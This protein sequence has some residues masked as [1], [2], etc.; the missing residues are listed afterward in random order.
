MDEALRYAKEG[1]PRQIKRAVF[2]SG[3]PPLTPDTHNIVLADEC[4]DVI[5][6]PTVHVFG[7]SDPYAVGALALFDVCVQDSATLFD[8]GNG[9]IIPR[10]GRTLKELGGAVRSMAKACF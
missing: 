10:D 5:D 4:E 6:I 2:F 1:R 3:W 8:H 9:H 7:A